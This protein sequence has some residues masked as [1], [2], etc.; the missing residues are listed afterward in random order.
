MCY[1]G[2]ISFFYGWI[3]FHCVHTDTH[4]L[5]Y[6]LTLYLHSSVDGWFGCFHVLSIVNSAAMDIGVDASFQILVFS[7]YIY[8]GMELL[9]HIIVFS[10]LRSDFTNLHF[11]QCW[12]RISFF[13]HL[14]QHLLFVD[15]FF[16]FSTSCVACRI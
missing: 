7:K 15:I 16:F 8:L 2:D 13:S 12:R 11:H 14:C 4:S 6:W 9:Y 5:T 10:F 1:S 3:I